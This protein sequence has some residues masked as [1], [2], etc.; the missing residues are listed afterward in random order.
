M[1]MELGSDGMIC[2]GIS[3]TRFSIKSKM[4]RIII[5]QRKSNE[6]LEI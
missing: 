5:S 4:L 2:V 1:Q 6:G 3:R